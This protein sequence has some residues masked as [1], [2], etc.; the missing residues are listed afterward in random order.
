MHQL[1]I[2]LFIFCQS[3]VAQEKMTLTLPSQQDGGHKFYHDL[4]HTALTD[5]GYNVTINTPMEHIPQKRA[6]KMVEA[7]QLSLTWLIG[8]E[9]RNQKYIPVR[10]PLTNGMI[11]KRILLIPPELQ[12]EFDTINNLKDL[13]QSKMV[14][15]LG[16]NWYDIDVWKMNQLP[17]HVE[18]GEWRTLY[19]KISSDG[20]VNY[21]PRG[22][23]EIVDEAE[24][25]N[26]LA[27]EQRL[28][29]VYDKDFYF[30]LSESAAGYQ[31]VI[32]KA[33][34]QAKASGLM[35]KLIEKH[36]QR[37]Y[38]RITPDQRVVINLSLPKAS[39]HK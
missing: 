16:M 10:V 1:V 39:S 4:L 11:G 31:T 6:V 21:F 34:Q 30:Y 37:T 29:L 33:L 25:N 19:S 22:M 36:W 28:M 26:H 32:E 13:Q 35:G 20:E 15:G 23:T 17:V 18:D 14:A 38:E 5:A 27:I 2:V 12:N 7:G 3:V 9:Q 24:Q 8:T